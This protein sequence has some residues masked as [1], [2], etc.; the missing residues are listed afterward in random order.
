MDCIRRSSYHEKRVWSKRWSVIKSLTLACTVSNQS[1]LIVKILNYALT[2]EHLENAFYHE[3]LAKYTRD[4]FGKAAN[5][6]QDRGHFYDN[7]Y[8]VSMDE[9][10]HVDF[11]TRAL[12]DDAVAPCTYDFPFTD[13]ASFLALAG[14]LEG[15][16]V[17]A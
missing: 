8:E 10:T 1:S 7:L 15:V 2:L 11:L 5:I 6:F 4:A 16:G 13:P 9:Q 17:S 3:G 14:V 12:G